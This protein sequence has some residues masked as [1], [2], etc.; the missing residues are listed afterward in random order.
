ML[1]FL[2]GSLPAILRPQWIGILVGVY[3]GDATPG[4]L[5]SQADVV[6]WG[7]WLL[8]QSRAVW[9][10]LQNL[11]VPHLSS[12][13]GPWFEQFGLMGSSRWAWAAML[14]AS[15]AALLLL[16]FRLRRSSDSRVMLVLAALAFFIP[17]LGLSA[18]PRVDW[19]HPAR[20]MLGSLLALTL[21]MRWFIDQQ[22][23]RAIVLAAVVSMELPRQYRTLSSLKK[24]S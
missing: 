15:F 21:L 12:F 10:Y 23:H 8:T 4:A 24:S 2:A 7:S 3:Q 16:F 6:P 1:I 11:I 19:Y 17:T 18:V 9:I 13:H 14:I 5:A 22:R 20:Q